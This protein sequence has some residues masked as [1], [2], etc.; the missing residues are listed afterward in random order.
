MTR[1]IASL[2]AGLLWAGAAAAQDDASCA[3]AGH[4][5]YADYR[6]SGVAAAE[7][8]KQLDI[9][10]LGSG[11]STLRGPSGA[12]QAYPGRLQAALAKRL[13][14]AAVKVTSYA[15]SGST[16]EEMRKEIQKILQG[17]KLTLVVWQAGTVDA[18]RGVDPDTFQTALA[19]GVEAL[20][21]A[22]V[23]V[24]LMNM[25]YSPRTESMIALTPYADIMRVVAQQHEVPMF[26]RFAIMRHWHEM[27]TFDLLAATKSVDTAVRVHD[28]IAQ[29][30][31]DVIIEGAKNDE[32]QQVKALQ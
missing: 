8:K 25:Q 10:V 23:D 1:F 17:S 22:G 13:P 3:V 20:Q 28:C 2:L 11:S 12:D 26:D 6:L 32:G 9:A 19:S 21:G 14:G 5:A 18:M 24:I 30:L 4:L 15:K 16:T 27:G 7:K 31:A 29:L